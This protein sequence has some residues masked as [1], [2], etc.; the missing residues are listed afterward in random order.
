MNIVII[1][2]YT[3][4]DKN[5]K[6]TAKKWSKRGQKDPCNKTPKKWQK[7]AS[8]R[9]GTFRGQK[10]GQKRPFLGQKMTIFGSKNDIFGV[11][12]VLKPSFLARYGKPPFLVWK[13]PQILWTMVLPQNHATNLSISVLLYKGGSRGSRTP[14]IAWHTPFFY[15]SGI[16]QGFGVSFGPVFGPQKWCFL[17]PLFLIVFWPL[18]AMF[19]YWSFFDHFLII[20][21]PFFINIYT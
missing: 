11:T 13:T 12:G 6:N 2:K 18:F 4:S 9:G 17:P 5:N 14:K 8:K 20:F 7:T 21:W 1:N 16:K 19:I 10:R 15:I 3:Y